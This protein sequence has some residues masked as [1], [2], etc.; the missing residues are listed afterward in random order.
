MRFLLL[1]DIELLEPAKPFA[2]RLT[3]RKPRKANTLARGRSTRN[4][5][6]RGAQLDFLI[7]PGRRFNPLS[8]TL[9]VA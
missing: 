5:F 1:W 4:I 7:L 9:R 3:E 2:V 6:R 8:N